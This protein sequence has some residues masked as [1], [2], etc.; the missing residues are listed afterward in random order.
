MRTMGEVRQAKW[1]DSESSSGL[2]QIEFLFLGNCGFVMCKLHDLTTI[3]RLAEPWGFFVCF[4]SWRGGQI[5]FWHFRKWFSQNDENNEVVD[6][7]HLSEN[8]INVESSDHMPEE[9]WFPQASNGI[10]EFKGSSRVSSLLCKLWVPATL[11][12]SP[13]LPSASLGCPIPSTY[14]EANNSSSWDA[15]PPLSS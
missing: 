8:F 14:C 9:V 15:L 4:V 3:L 10:R 12:G 2:N 13:A 7:S 5:I 11:R 1:L 6:K